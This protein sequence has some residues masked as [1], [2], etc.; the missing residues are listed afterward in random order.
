MRE[1]LD[2]EVRGH[3]VHRRLRAPRHHAKAPR[4]HLER[5]VQHLEARGPAG[6][7]VADDDARAVDRQRLLGRAG[8]DQPLRLALRGLVGVAKPLAPLE[9]RLEDQPLAL[10]RHVR[11]ADIVEVR[12]RLAGQV[13]HPPRAVDVDRPRLRDRQAEADRRRPVDHAHRA[14]HQLVVRPQRQPEPLLLE[15]RA[16]HLHPPRR[17]RQRLAPQL[18]R[19]QREP[20][21]LRLPLVATAHQQR[22]VGLRL[23]RQQVQDDL[24]PQKPGR[25][26][27]HRGRIAHRRTM[28]PRR[29]RRKPQAR[30][31]CSTRPLAPETTVAALATLA[32][33]VPP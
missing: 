11:G 22:Q 30:V 31:T 28:P 27:D 9:L 19:Q 1:R 20:P 8:L 10:A 24:T 32:S 18:R 23:A 7:R 2:H 12:P 6:A 21:R 5:P 3:D 4:E 14:P 25:A 15:V 17:V 33:H 29:L 26:R 13:Q 16:H